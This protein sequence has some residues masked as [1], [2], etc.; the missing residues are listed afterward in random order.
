MEVGIL[1]LSKD[2]IYANSSIAG[3]KSSYTDASIAPGIGYQLRK[4]DASFR[5]QY[6]LSD[7]G[8]RLYYYNVRLGYNILPS[9]KRNDV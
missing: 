6:N 5:L 1:K 3:F 9:K 8:Y 4:L 7:A 2:R